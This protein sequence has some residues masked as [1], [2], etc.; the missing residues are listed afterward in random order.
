[1]FFG[2]T[3]LMDDP[4][5]Q[6]RILVE[7]NH[8]NLIVVLARL[9]F[10]LWRHLCSETTWKPEIAVSWCRKRWEAPLVGRKI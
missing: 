1:M 5:I 2:F 7:A 4:R 10:R 9:I 3:S 6:V 8:P